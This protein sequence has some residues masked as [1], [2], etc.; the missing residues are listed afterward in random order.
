MRYSDKIKTFLIAISC[1]LVGSPLL[2]AQQYNWIVSDFSKIKTA[3]KDAGYLSYGIHYSYTSKKAGGNIVDSLL[4]VC[5]SHGNSYY[6]K[7]GPAEFVQNN[8]YNL[9]VHHQT[10]SIIINNPVVKEPGVLSTINMDTAFLQNHVDS[11]LV[12]EDK[13]SKTISLLFGNASPYI[14]YTITFSKKN[15]LIE[16]INYCIKQPDEEGEEG[17]TDEITFSMLFSKYDR[18][19]FDDSFFSE[20]G[21][22][23]MNTSGDF[24][25]KGDY[26]TYQIRNIKGN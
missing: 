6:S 25:G 1:L 26:S 17:S 22:V 12:K 3:Y 24:T 20:K 18:S 9:A 8:Q 21:Y 23:I 10:K 2:M 14:F 16:K 4:I 15:Y 11:V 19:N 5:K 7:I 13:E